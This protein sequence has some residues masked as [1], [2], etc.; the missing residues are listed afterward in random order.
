M[1]KGEEAKEERRS[2]G[3]GGCEADATK[4]KKRLKRVNR[5]IEGKE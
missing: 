4:Q 3:G 1:K 5:T 2:K